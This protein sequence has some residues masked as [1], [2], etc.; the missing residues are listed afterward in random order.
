MP[1]DSA[2]PSPAELRGAVL[3]TIF[4]L[5]VFIMVMIP[6]QSFSKFHLLAKKKEEHKRLKAEGIKP[7]K[8]SFAEIKYYNNRDFLALAG[9]RAVG[10]YIEQ[11]FVFLPLMWLHALFVN[12]TQSLSICLAYTSSRML[13]PIVFI[14]RRRF[15]SYILISTLPG[16]LVLLYLWCTIVLECLFD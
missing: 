5:S 11:G 15:D 14:S 13:Y 7:E 16:Y 9:D 10:N 2:F 8:V 12:N 1:S 3:G 4:Y 6:F